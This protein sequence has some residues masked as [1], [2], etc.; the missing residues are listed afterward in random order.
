MVAYNFIIG[1]IF[2]VT[3]FISK[4]QLAKSKR[5]MNVYTLSQRFQLQENLR[6]IAILKRIMYSF[7]ICVVVMMSCFMSSVFL[8]KDAFGV[9]LLKD[10]ESCF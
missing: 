4:F 8:M 5:S 3:I 6:M 7:V 1:T 9:S 10:N 2:Q